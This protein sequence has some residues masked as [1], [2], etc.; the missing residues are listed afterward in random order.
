MNVDVAIVGGGPVGGSLA[1]ALA[2]TGLSV[3]L[4]EPR[5]PRPLPGAGFDRRAVAFHGRSRR[6]L[7]RRRGWERFLPEPGAPPPGRRVVGGAGSQKQFTVQSR[8]R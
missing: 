4:V 8:G 1:R 5:I 7:Q 3:A 6:F 2:P